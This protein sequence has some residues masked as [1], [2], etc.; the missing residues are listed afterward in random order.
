M[1]S[2]YLLLCFLAAPV[3]AKS[4]DMKA[5]VLRLKPGQDVYKEITSYVSTHKLMAA[6]I[7]SAVG[8]VN[9][10][11][12]RF[13]NKKDGTLI[14]GPLEVLS[15]SGTTSVEGTHLHMSVADGEGKTTGGHLLEGSK[16]YTT[17]EIVMADYKDITFKRTLDKTY[18]YEEL[19][20]QPTNLRSK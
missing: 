2:R 11:N 16:V 15:L 19:D 9:E 20:V 6:S 13:A 5:H 14:K 8:S 4:Y 7:I 17:L 18:G 3:W 10:A 1:L 12:L